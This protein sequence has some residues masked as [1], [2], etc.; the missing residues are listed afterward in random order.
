LE[1]QHSY[2]D[3]E[4]RLCVRDCSADWTYSPSLYEL[5]MVFHNRT[6]YWHLCRYIS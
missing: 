3:L 5:I 4:A 1:T 6:F 2:M